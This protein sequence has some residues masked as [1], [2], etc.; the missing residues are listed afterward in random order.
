MQRFLILCGLLVSLAIPLSM[1]QSPIQLGDIVA[2]SGVE[3]RS[4]RISGTDPVLVRQ[5][6][7][8]VALHGGL[9]EVSGEADFSLQFNPA[10]D[11]VQVSISSG[12]QSLWDQSFSGLSRL[13][14]LYR[15]ADAV[16]ARILG[17]QGFFRSEL[18]FVSSRTGHAEIYQA[19]ILFENVR[20][21]TRDRSET[22]SPALSPDGRTLLYTSYH[23]NGFPDI[24]QIELSSGRRTLFAG[25]RGTNS[26]A[27]F[28][29]NGTEVAMV[30]SSAGNSE[31]FV[32]D[33]N[34]QQ[35]R[36]LTRNASLEADPTWSPDGRRIAFTSDQMGKPQ[37]YTMDRN[38]ADFR[39]VRTDIS[40]NCSEPNWNPRDPNLLVFT[41]A[42][43]SSFEV[44]LYDFNRSQSVIISSGSGD[45]VHPIW[46]ND[47]RHVIF[48]R[49]T[50]RSS[51][52]M[53]LDTVTKRIAPLSPES[54]NNARQATWA[55]PR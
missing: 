51:R 27:V 15:A 46:L 23:G 5:A 3:S 54:L 42:V 33:R 30:L 19:D 31:I 45:A 40:R 16:V 29:P 12:G 25:Y 7:R 24:F 4:V 20:Q 1:A 50:P 10:G 37:I 43:G 39:R 52:L 41:A 55:Y 22:L 6:S 11:G 26:G 38:G 8:L 9:Q 18:A 13:D 36:R 44:V 49:R 17:I 53:V 35:L 2:S 28:S 34:G 32:S 21:L 47:G 14:A 48:T